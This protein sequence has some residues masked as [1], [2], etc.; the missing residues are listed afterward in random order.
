VPLNLLRNPDGTW[1]RLDNGD[2]AQPGCEEH[3]C[4]DDCKRKYYV[5]VDWSSSAADAIANAQT[6]LLAVGDALLSSNGTTLLHPIS[7]QYRDQNGY[8]LVGDN[9]LTKE[10]WEN[11]VATLIAEPPSGGEN[12]PIW[13]TDAI[14]QVQ[15]SSQFDVQILLYFYD[16]VRNYDQNDIE[17]VREA[18]KARNDSAITPLMFYL[19]SY[20]G[21]DSSS[22]EEMFLECCEGTDPNDL[23][24]DGMSC[25]GK[26]LLSI[27]SSII[28]PNCGLIP[29]PIPAAPLEGYIKPGGV[30]NFNSPGDPILSTLW[31]DWEDA[32]GAPDGAWNPNPNFRNVAQAI[33]QSQDIQTKWF[34]GEMDF[35]NEIPEGA[36]IT[37]IDLDVWW[38][39]ESLRTDGQGSYGNFGRLQEMSLSYVAVSGADTDNRVPGTEQGTGFNLPNASSYTQDS[40]TWEDGTYDLNTP[41]IINAIN[42]KTFGFQFWVLLNE[43]TPEAVGAG[44]VLVDLDAAFMRINYLEPSG[45]TGS[46]LIQIDDTGTTRCKG[47]KERK[48]R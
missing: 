4:G 14:G 40:F 5:D 45:V 35:Q 47:C 8:N 9:I 2:W 27:N 39:Q 36:T 10:D 12:I 20:N 46:S 26:F 33:C 32:E 6:N 43:P 28:D 25:F 30:G 1:K 38:N 34:V 21:E 44:A 31:R 17:T 11:A 15:E 24:A 41:E 48:V 3:C 13:M 16:D 7:L 37:S 29:C 18:M 42:N 19:V 23:T 22:W